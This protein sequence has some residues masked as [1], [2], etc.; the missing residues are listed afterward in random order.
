MDREV[1]GAGGELGRLGERL[2]VWQDEVLASTHI[3][4]QVL[5]AVM[6]SR[7]PRPRA[8]RPWIWSLAV[9][10]VGA[11]AVAVVASRPAPLTYKVDGRAYAASTG[12]LIVAPEGHDVGVLFSD[13]T[14]LALS[15]G[16]QARIAAVDPHGARVILERGRAHASV[17]PLP[18]ARW[19]M[20]AGPFEVA[21]KGTRF[22]LAWDPATE[23]MAL[24]LEDGAV[25]VSGS[26]LGGEKSLVA[27][28][29]LRAF[30]KQRRLEI[31]RVA[32]AP[33]PPAAIAQEEEQEQP[34]EEEAPVVQP[35]RAA[36]PRHRPRARVHAPA[37]PDW[38]VLAA[39]HRYRDALAAAEE[40]GFAEQC[41]R[42][43]G[44]DLLL[45]GDAARMA[46]VPD[47]ARQ[48]YEAAH[49][50]HPRGDR[51]TYALGMLAFQRGKYHDAGT[52]FAR[53]LREQPNGPLVEEA[54]AHL[55]ESWDRAGATADARRAAEQYLLRH[56]HGAHVE[57]ARRVL[58]GE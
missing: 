22:D 15:A 6:A 16:A 52:W 14:A 31:G 42:A 21:V 28:E 47:R 53:Y 32:A 44:A 4:P 49:A 3:E 20:V 57:T 40:A 45:L 13:G 38:R 26:F 27:G 23:E 10:G 43:S 9:V 39:G 1:N 25:G 29:R 35:V 7:L 17:V 37:T 33:E 36:P 24:L 58:S 41:A 54:H 46:G 2:A 18:G 12:A 30:N 19:R 5:R 55:V 8:A 50:R 51:T 48:A 34:V 56:P 11:A